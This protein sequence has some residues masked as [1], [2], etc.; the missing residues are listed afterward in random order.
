VCGRCNYKTCKKSQYDRHLS[1]DKHTFRTIETTMEQKS[2]ESSTSKQCICGI[3]FNSRTTLW[4]HKKKC[5]F[6]ESSDE[7][8]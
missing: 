1:T 2:S 3:C 4:R 5:K 6:E 8:G 7:E